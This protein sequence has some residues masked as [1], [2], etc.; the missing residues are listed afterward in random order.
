MAVLL[1]LFTYLTIIVGGIAVVAKIY[2]LATMPIH[3]RWELYPV[4]KE[5]E[6]VHHGGSF[7]EESDWWTKKRHE[8]FIS[9]LMHMLPEM[10]FI[11]AMYDNNRKLWYR[12]FPF[13]F[14]LY[15]LI[16]TAGLVILLALADIVGL[17]DNALVG[18]ISKLTSLVGVI[19]LALATIGALALLHRRL[20][21]EDLKDYTAARDIF[22]L[23]AFLVTFAC[24]WLGFVF[25]ADGGISTVVSYV[26]ALLT[27]NLSASVGGFW[28]GMAFLLFSFFIMYVPLSHMSHFIAKYFMWHKIRWDDEPNLPGGKIEK[29]V[30]T[31]V[32]YPVTWSASHLAADGKKNWVDIALEDIPQK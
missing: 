29:E 30:T 20:A 32:S 11:K 14:G 2:R 21:D 3:L 27:F 4:P 23:V 25:S 5:A 17:Q 16:G 1:H 24:A 26:S 8:S 12:S 9:E 28:A 7:Y 22:N 6:K 31:L 15:M 10:L 18:I 13:H 19:G